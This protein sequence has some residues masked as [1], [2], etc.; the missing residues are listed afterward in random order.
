MLKNFRYKCKK[1]RARRKW[2][3]R[4]LN[5][6]ILLVNDRSKTRSKEK[7]KS[8]QKRETVEVA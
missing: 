3:S 1:K 7:R 8:S 5:R 6:R 2:I 4:E